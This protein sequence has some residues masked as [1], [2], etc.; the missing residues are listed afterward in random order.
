MVPST[1]RW[2]E[3]IQ[4]R[5]RFVLAAAP[6]SSPWAHRAKRNS[7]CESIF[8]AIYGGELNA[9]FTAWLAQIPL[10]LR[11][12]Q[13]RSVRQSNYFSA[14]FRQRKS[15]L[16]CNNCAVRATE[17]PTMPIKVSSCLIRSSLREIV[18][19]NKLLSHTGARRHL[20]G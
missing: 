10:R 1:E 7:V 14:L 11:S 17:S 16:S 19:D 6:A 3:A 2:P 12:G 20:R 8:R 15:V 13:A 18:K 5:T 9:A 4:V